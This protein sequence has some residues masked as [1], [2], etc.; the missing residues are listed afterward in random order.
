MRPPDQLKPN[1]ANLPPLRTELCHAP[2]GNADQS[3]ET[4]ADVGLG[5]REGARV[6]E[7]T[8]V[9]TVAGCH[10]SADVGHGKK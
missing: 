5:T 2:S 3:L 4:V 9:H 7:F 1:G 8:I 6:G 10:L